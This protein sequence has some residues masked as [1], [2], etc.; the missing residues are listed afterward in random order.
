MLNTKI[1]NE[2]RAKELIK[3]FEDYLVKEQVVIP[4]DEWDQFGYDPYE[5][6][7]SDWIQSEYSNDESPKINE[8]SLINLNNEHIDNNFEYA[9]FEYLDTAMEDII[10]DF[11]DKK[12]YDDEELKDFDRE[13]LNNSEDY[14][15]NYYDYV[16]IDY[17]FN[18]FYHNYEIPT[19]ILID[20]ENLNTEGS[21]LEETISC[22][23][24][25]LI[26]EENSS[27]LKVKEGKSD[28][29]F[30]LDRINDYGLSA[31]GFAGFRYDDLFTYD[32]I[33]LLTVT[34]EKLNEKISALEPIEGSS[35][36]LRVAEDNDLDQ[37]QVSDSFEKTIEYLE[38]CRTSIYEVFEDLS[39]IKELERKIDDEEKIDKN[40][41][42]DYVDEVTIKLFTSQGYELS[43][44]CDDEKVKN[45]KFLSSFLEEMINL[46]NIGVYT[47]VTILSIEELKDAIENKEINIERKTVFGMF[48]PACGGGSLMGIFLEKDFKLPL[49]Y[50]RFSNQN[51]SS[52][53][54]S[55][56]DV[57]GSLI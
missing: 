12:D 22:I 7:I 21:I 36:L 24:Q 18:L 33:N 35:I 13:V 28:A 54:Y 19:D 23:R 45:S 43:D 1:A 31:L 47:A 17:N 5:F 55:T 2:Q 9:E 11:L 6:D 53:G 56:T 42:N 50:V 30:V 3:E 44:L 52:Y 57:Y 25:M 15:L 29:E 20:N 40:N 27:L 14:G 39:Q 38:K 32:L 8:E 37:Y 41:I 48:D 26:N 34:L 10:S 51:V 46:Y 4:Y 49:S 16:E